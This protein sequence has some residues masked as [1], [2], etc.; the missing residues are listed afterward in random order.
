MPLHRVIR[1]WRP[2]NVAAFRDWSGGPPP[3]LGAEDLEGWAVWASRMLAKQPPPELRKVGQVVVIDPI[4]TDR[5]GWRLL[6]YCHQRARSMI[7]TLP[8]DAEPAL[9]EL[10]A[11][12]DDTR[13]QLLGW[14]F[15]EE[16]ERP[17]GFSSSA[18]PVSPPSR[19]SCS[20]PICMTAPGSSS[21]PPRA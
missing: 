13:R 1:P 12:V 5:A 10:Y 6:D 19:A 14:G 4:S 15:V 9:A 8:F 11:A 16:A 18:P 7:V 3:G 21:T 2:K 17:E 20:A